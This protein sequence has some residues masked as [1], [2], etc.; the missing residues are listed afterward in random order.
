MINR[1]LFTFAVVL[2]IMASSSAVA[3]VSGLPDFTELVEEAGPA[4]V[5]IRV[6]EFGEGLDS[7]DDR[8]QNPHNQEDIPEFFRRFFD[9]PGMPDPRQP[10]VAQVPV[11]S[12]NPTG[13]S[14]PTTT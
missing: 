4:V 13:T 11:S 8:A 7:G 2:L 6:T 3:R 14:S 10:D 1:I 12:S 5:N 9:V